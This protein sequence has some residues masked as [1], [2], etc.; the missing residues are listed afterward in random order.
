MILVVF[1]CFVLICISLNKN[2]NYFH[3]PRSSKYTDTCGHG[4]AGYSAVT[5]GWF[6]A[7]NL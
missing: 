1:V 3:L 7:M 2:S 4:V 5:P 6:R